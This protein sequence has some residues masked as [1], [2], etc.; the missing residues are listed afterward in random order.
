MTS[1]LDKLKNGV[2]LNPRMGFNYF[3]IHPSLGWVKIGMT[4]KDVAGRVKSNINSMARAG[5]PVSG[6]R[7]IHTI[8]SN[9]WQALEKDIQEQFSEWAV[10]LG[11]RWND[12]DGYT[13]LYWLVDELTGNPIP[14]AL[15]ILEALTGKDFSEELANTDIVHYQSGMSIRNPIVDE[16]GAYLTSKGA[17]VRR[18]RRNGL[19]LTANTSNMWAPTIEIGSN[20]VMWVKVNNTNETYDFE[21]NHQLN[22]RENVDELLSM[23]SEISVINALDD[24]IADTRTKLAQ[25]KWENSRVANALEPEEE[26]WAPAPSFMTWEAFQIMEEISFSE[27]EKLYTPQLSKTDISKQLLLTSQMSNEEKHSYLHTLEQRIEVGDTAWEPVY[28]ALRNVMGMANPVRTK[29]QQVP[30]H[31]PQNPVARF[32]RWVTGN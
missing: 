18:H 8:R 11:S 1:T 24:V 10:G 13:E 31:L 4:E 30:Q 22:I 19:L 20:E 12:I 28:L 16:I 27:R 25:A 23:V 3:T 15:E 9:D 14:E 29:P 32:F 21:W 7:C 6:S 26:Y 17:S 5:L 2:A